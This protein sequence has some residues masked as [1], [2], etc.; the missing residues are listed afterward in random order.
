[1]TVRNSELRLQLRAA[2]AEAARDRAERLELLVK[3]EKLEEQ[4]NFW[5]RDSAT[6]WDKCANRRLASQNVE[7]IAFTLWRAEAERAAP[8]EA[9]AAE[10][11]DTRDRWLH[12]ARAVAALLN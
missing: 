1:M 10:K 2:K 12:S 8:P 9:F 11:Q 6:A 5:Q 7:Q 3:V 4:L